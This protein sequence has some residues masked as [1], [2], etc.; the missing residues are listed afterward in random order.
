MGYTHSVNTPLC[1]G[2]N[3]ISS[4]DSGQWKIQVSNTRND[5]AVVVMI[6]CSRRVMSGSAD[7]LSTYRFH[8]LASRSPFT[9]QGFSL[10][11][12][13]WLCSLRLPSSASIRFL[14]RM[15]NYWVSTPVLRLKNAR[16]PRRHSPRCHA[17]AICPDVNTCRMLV[18]GPR[19]VLVS[20]L[21][22]T[23]MIS[24]E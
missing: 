7:I 22:H 16:A 24:R 4:R 17:V 13:T 5:S 14:E 9:V 10:Y 11:S 15:L 19:I 18:K 8:C 1:Q 12:K 20:R 23:H 21:V 3:C 6:V 2:T